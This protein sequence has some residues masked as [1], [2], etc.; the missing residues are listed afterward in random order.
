MGLWGARQLTEAMG[1]MVEIASVPGTGSTFTVTL[2]LKS[3][4]DAG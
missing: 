2:P 4:K 1:G 3:A